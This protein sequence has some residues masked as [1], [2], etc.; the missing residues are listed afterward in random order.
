MS[1]LGSRR[2]SACAWGRRR[3]QSQSSLQHTGTRRVTRRDRACGAWTHCFRLSDPGGQLRCRHLGPG[4]PPRPPWSQSNRFQVPG[5]NLH[6]APPEPRPSRPLGSG[7]RGCWSP[8]L[9]KGR[10]SAPRE[11][12][13]AKDNGEVPIAL[14]SLPPQPKNHS[15]T[16]ACSSLRACLQHVPTPQGCVSAHGP[17]TPA[18]APPSEPTAATR[19]ANYRHP[20]VLKL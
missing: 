6:R 4:L 10:P 19:G 9:A 8:G 1:C 5:S 16:G 18:K 15:L 2:V 11:G 3:W 20:S 14:G 13:A 17:R 7:G 12:S